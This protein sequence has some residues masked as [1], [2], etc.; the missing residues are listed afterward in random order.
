MQLFTMR[1]C[2]FFYGL[3]IIRQCAHEKDGAQAE[4]QE[5]IIGQF[6]SGFGNQPRIDGAHDSEAKAGPTADGAI[7][8]AAKMFCGIDDDCIDDGDGGLANEGDCR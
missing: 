5:Q 8:N 7:I 3:G 1:L 6:N 4:N 2:L